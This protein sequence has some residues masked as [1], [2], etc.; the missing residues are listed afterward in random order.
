MCIPAASCS[1]ICN[2]RACTHITFSFHFSP[3]FLFCLSLSLLSL[4]SLYHLS[5]T[6]THTNKQVHLND[7]SCRRLWSAGKCVCVCVCTCVRV[8]VDTY[9]RMCVC[10]YV[11]DDDDCYIVPV[12][13]CI[14]MYTHVRVYVCVCVGTS[15]ML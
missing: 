4:S 3:P 12:R 9:V 6:H 8:C 15:S 2:T 1:H 10:V 7:Q 14:H 13:A 11:C 5:S